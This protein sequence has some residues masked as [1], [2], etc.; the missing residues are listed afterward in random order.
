MAAEKPAYKVADIKL[1]ELG[2]KDIILSENE[3]PGLMNLREKYGAE[4]PLK[5]CRA[6][7][8]RAPRRAPPAC[9][10][11]SRRLP[12]PLAAA[13]AAAGGTRELGVSSPQARGH[14]PRGGNAPRG[15]RTSGVHIMPT[16]QTARACRSLAAYRTLA[17]SPGRAR[18]AEAVHISC[19]SFQ[20]SRALFR[21][22][23]CARVVLCIQA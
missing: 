6:R 17:H 4:K 16:R 10:A 2:R 13:P 15:C 23:Q 5:V 12:C 3:M 8:P 14:I 9:P 18:P 1:A 21:E 22:E 19:A 11:A 7:H 20:V